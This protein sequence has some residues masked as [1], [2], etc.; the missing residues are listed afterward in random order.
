M[1]EIRKNKFSRNYENTFF[2]EFSECVYNSFNEKGIE[3][4][5]IGSPF[6]EVDERLQIDVLLITHNVVCIIDFKNYHGEIKLPTGNNFD[7]GRWK[8]TDDK[9]IK[10]GSSINPF[11]Q[12][13][14][15]KSRFINVSKKY[16]EKN[17]PQANTFDPLHLIRIVC[18]QNDIELIGNIPSNESLNFFILNKTNFLEGILDIIDVTD[19]AVNL[20]TDS[21]SAFKKIFRATK[22]NFDDKPLEN[23]LKVFADKSETLKYKTLYPDQNTALTDIKTFLENPDQRVFVLNGS[24]NSGKTYL[25]PF[26]QDIA[27]NLGI[28]ETQI[29]ASSS[30]VKNNLL[31][32]RGL[33]QVNSIYSYIYG[34]L[35]HEILEDKNDGVAKTKT[36][37]GD[38]PEKNQLEE[39]PIKNCDDADNAL[40]I[41]DEAQ[42]VSDSFYQSIDLIFGTGYLLK[43]FL[44]FS[45][46]IKTKRKI[47]FIGDPYQL[48]LGKKDESALN[49]V[50][51]KEAYK[52]KTNDYQLLDKPDFSN[53][54][55]EALFCVDKIRK[56]HFNSLRFD[57]NEEV[58]FLT[59]KEFPKAVKNIIHKKI[60]G[61]ILCFSNEESQKVNYWI[62]E[63]IVKN[64]EDI[65]IND[66]ILFNNNISIEDGNDP[67]AEPKK[68]YNGQFAT[69][70]SL[71]NKIIKEPI[72]NK[73]K[74]KIILKFREVSINLNET[75]HNAKVFSFE[76]YR[77]NSKSELS[78]NEIRAF[79][80]LLYRLA[81]K[82]LE[83][84][85]NDVHQLDDE[86]KILLG[87]LKK[88]KKVKSKVI[89]KIQRIL[90]RM[91]S[92]N[93]YKYKNAALLKFGWAMT[94]DKSPS[95][96][97]Q[98]V[99]INTEPG[100]RFNNSKT[101][102]PY[103][104]MIYT[105][106]TRAEKKVSLINYKPISPFDKTEMVDNNSGI[107]PAD[108][109]FISD[110][111]IAEKKLMELKEYVSNKLA[112]NQSTIEKIENLNWQ[113]RYHLKNDQLSTIISFSYNG[114]GMFKI[115]TLAG[116]D[117]A[118]G[119]YVIDIIKKKTIKFDF[120][121]I[122]DARRK[123]I[124]E[125]LSNILGNS[126]VLFD[127]I[128]QNNF[129]DKIRLYENENELEI[130]VNYTG[131]GA[132]SKITATYYSDPTI[133][134]HFKNAIEQIKL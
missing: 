69:V 51:L 14:K 44:F 35:K 110:N 123:T 22:Y 3:G 62:K 36:A 97:W 63:S 52:L 82:E 19:R 15:Q 103:F 8:T 50:Y 20:N 4:V 100:S 108:I 2:R 109:L 26:I 48:Q 133:W 30:R 80:I 107:K 5:L 128:V 29:F 18:F 24:V 114:K 89:Q 81:E 72:I 90:S 40:Y 122:K 59:E 94:I 83:N 127:I 132:F 21:F 125:Q 64:G 38:N 105:G 124:Y 70:I 76:N 131:D 41:V 75:G 120:S 71:A 66:L 113:E 134:N 47:I 31:L 43:D 93:Y 7:F 98:E 9:P 121:I 27:Y 58:C 96:K 86:F 104:R 84:F 10:G 56:K 28:Q 46:L 106:F 91:P 33:E 11:Q 39:I 68:I 45:D 92:S 55:R 32:T 95:Y 74:E 61:H 23:K 129:K 37:E 130:E 101:H 115:P 65:A 117:N 60:D 119:N 85:A 1:L 116:G 79:K 53:I 34:G 118:Y 73:K 17:I 112:L 42:L 67:F 49:P 102:E 126:Q 111:P 57:E 77:L 54:N 88:G 99:I 6:C 16:I 12:L 78:K 87:D 25:I 13:K